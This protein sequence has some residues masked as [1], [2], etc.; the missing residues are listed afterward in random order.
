M[1]LENSKKIPQ[2]TPELLEME[3]ESS[4][5]HAHMVSQTPGRIRFRV[6]HLHREK[7]KME[8]IAHA[9]K[10]CL[11]IYRVRTNVASGS[12]TVF[13]A[14]EHSSFDDVRA[15]LRD[16]GVIIRDIT[17]V[18]SIATNGKSDAAAEVTNAAADLN[19]RVKRATN[20]VVDLRVLIPLG[21]S[22]LA[23]RQLLVKGLQIEIIPWYVLAWYAFDSFIKFHYSSEPQL[24]TGNDTP[25]SF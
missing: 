18:K 25:K 8:P 19:Q 13:H 12:I 21:F 3:S 7:H 14:Q 15:I 10:E 4:P 23:L 17:D 22:A 24:S 2:L 11:E 1:V 16:L 6:A 9:L 20:G 5:I